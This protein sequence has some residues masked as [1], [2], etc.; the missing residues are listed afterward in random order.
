MPLLRN[1]L[2]QRRSACAL[3]TLMNQGTIIL[4]NLAKGRWGEDVAALLG[5]L[6]MNQVALAALSCAARPASR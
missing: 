4:A 3:H 5:S 6:L 1:I 2:G